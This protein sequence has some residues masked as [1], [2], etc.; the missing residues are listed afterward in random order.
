[1]VSTFNFHNYDSLADSHDKID[2]RRRKGEARRDL[3]GDLCWAASEGDLGSLRRFAARGVALDAA[4]YDGR[5]PVHLAASEGHVHVVEFFADQG[6]RLDP[7][8]RWGNTPLD[9]AQR[10]GHEAVAQLLGG[11][12]RISGKGSKGRR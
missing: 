11:V 3:V 4:D 5:T 12:D 8:D 1:M 7:C 9:D 2:P 6:V 10:E